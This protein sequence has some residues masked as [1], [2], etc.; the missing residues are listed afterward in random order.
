MDKFKLMFRDLDS[1]ELIGKAE[2]QVLPFATDLIMIGKQKFLV[3]S[4]IVNYD[5]RVAIVYGKVIE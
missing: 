3:N 1:K 5:I 4:K 2:S